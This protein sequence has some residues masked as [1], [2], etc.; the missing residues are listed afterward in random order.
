MRR[1][2]N[3]LD[4]RKLVD[5]KHTYGLFFSLSLSS[6]TRLN[7]RFWEP[8]FKKKRVIFPHL[9]VNSFK[10]HTFLGKEQRK[11]NSK[12][13]KEEGSQPIKARE[14]P[15]LWT[16][17]VCS[18][19]YNHCNQKVWTGCSLFEFFRIATHELLNLFV[20]K[21]SKTTFVTT[22]STSHSPTIFWSSRMLL[23]FHLRP[24]FPHTSQCF[25]PK[26]SSVTFQVPFSPLLP[27]CLLTGEKDK[28][29]TK[30][31]KWPVKF[32]SFFWAEH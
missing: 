3:F 18:I 30:T 13:T 20:E 17:R 11:K 25:I 8:M 27:S 4:R 9:W 21:Q 1:T 14:M 2:G 22:Q 5:W 32:E 28:K 10:A 23:V 19:I 24:A 6:E 26:T 15:K 16:M 29:G 31:I 7:V 12:S